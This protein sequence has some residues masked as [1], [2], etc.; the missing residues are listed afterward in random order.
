MLPH[1]HGHIFDFRGARFSFL[2]CLLLSWSIY[3]PL[4]RCKTEQRAAVSSG[5]VQPP[6]GG[7]EDESEKR[8]DAASELL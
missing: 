5:N 7:A 1:S 6:A 8:F 3:L 2:S 4:G